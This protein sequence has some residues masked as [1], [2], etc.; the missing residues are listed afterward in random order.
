MFLKS[1]V[2]VLRQHSLSWMLDG[3]RGAA[4][5]NSVYASFFKIVFDLLRLLGQ[6]LG[7]LTGALD[8]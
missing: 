6:F 1:F 7:L 2:V 3:V 4:V 8:D 5:S